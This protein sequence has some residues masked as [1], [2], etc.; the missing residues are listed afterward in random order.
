MSKLGQKTKQNKVQAIAC[1]GMLIALYLVV[2]QFTQSF[3]FGEHQMRI[4]TSLYALNY[5]F[6]F[7]VIPSGIA[8]ML[9]NF[10][11]GGLGHFDWIGG[12]IVG[13]ITGGGI[14]LVRK[15]RLTPLL[16]IPIII[17]VPGLC[18]PIWLS[19]ILEIPYHILAVSVC[20]GQIVPALVGYVL[21]T[22]LSKTNVL[23]NVGET[24]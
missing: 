16:I 10:L 11:F 22:E 23:K 24:K 3:A 15:F 20:I 14:Y 7:F 21:A 18:V 6:P 17:F 2:M 13:F 9:S 12:L 4:A 5:V 19:I 1:S 8:N